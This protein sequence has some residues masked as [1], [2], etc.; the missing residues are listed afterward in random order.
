MMLP[1]RAIAAVLAFAACARPAPRAD[2]AGTVCC[3]A[4][5]RAR[6]PAGTGK[7]YLSGDLPALGPWRADARLMSGT[8]RDRSVRVT[9]PPGTALEYKFTLGS[10][11]REAL[12]TSGKLPANHRLIVAHDTVVTHEVPAFK[13]DPRDYIA[14][15]RG[16]GVLGRLVYW[17]DVRSAFLGPARHVEIW[18]PPG[19]DS[20]ATARYPVLYMHDG[21]NLFD[22]RIANTGVDWGV[23]EAVVRLAG[24]GVIPPLIVVGVWSGA[25]RGFEYSPW[26]DGPD[27]ARFL[28][29]ELMPRVNR[30]F[31]TL[32]GPE[33]TAVMGS[34]MGGLLSFY[35]VT[36]HPD[37]FSACGCIST[38]F[39]L[40][41][42]VAAE[43]FPGFAADGLPDTTPYVVRD[44][45]AGL[46]APRTARYWFD[47]GTLSLDSAYG[48]T[49]EKIRA[50]LLEEGLV[51]G[52]DFVIRRYE[53]ATHNEASWRARLEDPLTFLFG[54]RT[55]PRDAGP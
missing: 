2:H 11:D 37:V 50:W 14:D 33:H 39:P 45:R 42:A 35:L 27:Y 48:P 15:W 25:R 52:R 6:V 23:D 24:R 49:H 51:E 31:R 19:Y 34:S 47:Y 36:H 40:S 7:V 32:T 43:V 46:D 12:T 13:R 9:V 38:H 55:P 44:I 26:D 4:T 28:I 10:W 17:T 29:E 1:T 3:T 8:R 30:S 20:A 22:P 21:Q 53:G 5:I 18:L 54:R 16:S 41:E